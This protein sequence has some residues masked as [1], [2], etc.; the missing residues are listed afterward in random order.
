M[1]ASLEKAFAQASQLPEEIQNGLASQMLEDIRAERKWD[2]TLAQSQPALE[3]MA[4]KAL[5]ARRSGK[6][7]RKGFDQL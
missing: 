4:R 5:T 3:K 7:T 2:E 1:T 6:I